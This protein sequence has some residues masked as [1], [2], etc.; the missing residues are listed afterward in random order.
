MRFG[1]TLLPLSFSTFTVWNPLVV[2]VMVLER[3]TRRTR[4]IHHLIN[5]DAPIQSPAINMW[6]KEAFMHTGWH[7]NQPNLRRNLKYESFICE[8][9]SIIILISCCVKLRS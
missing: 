6:R 1:H 4:R 7:R 8:R 5:V 3:T 9:G 2:E